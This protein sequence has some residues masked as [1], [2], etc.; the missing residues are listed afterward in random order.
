MPTIEPLQRRLN[1]GLFRDL[2]AGLQQQMVYWGKDVVHPAGNL[3]V[4]AGFSKRASE[5]L[6]GTSCYTLEWMGGRIVLHGSQAGWFGEDGGFLYIRPKHRCVKGLGGTPPTPGHWPQE[7]FQSCVDAEL[8][9]L[10]V[11][12]LRWWLHYEEWIRERFAEDYREQCYRQ[13]KRLPKSRAWLRPRQ[14]AG[15]I[16][17]LCERPE[18]LPR[19]AS[20]AVG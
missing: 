11:P 4:Q 3:L 14:A 6:Q 15:W 16:A 18:S 1:P 19:A 5:G 8:H 20:D 9:A 17:G 12:F 2:A 13:H 7:D 10:A